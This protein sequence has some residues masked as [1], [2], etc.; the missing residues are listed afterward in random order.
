MRRFAASWVGRILV[1]RGPPGSSGSFD[2]L[3]GVPC[4]LPEGAGTASVSFNDAGIAKIACLP[5]EGATNGVP[6][7]GYPFTNTFETPTHWGVINCGNTISFTLTTSPAGSEDWL[8]G[9]LNCSTGNT[10]T[11]SGDPGIM[12]DVVDENGN[13]TQSGVTSSVSVPQSSNPYF[14][15]VYGG[16]GVTG[17]YHLTISGT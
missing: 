5:T 12:F 10:I 14:I 7:D 9:L 1:V 3:D 16:S 2:Q 8:E 13:A 17:S 4:T 6:V 11:I 15:V